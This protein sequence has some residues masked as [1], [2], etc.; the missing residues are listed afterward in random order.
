MTASFRHLGEAHALPL[1]MAVTLAATSMHKKCH[2]Q[3]MHRNG[4]PPPRWRW[5]LGFQRAF[6]AA[7]EGTRV[8]GLAQE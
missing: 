7:D 4:K 3:K 6:E 2:A 5:R 8:E 1:T